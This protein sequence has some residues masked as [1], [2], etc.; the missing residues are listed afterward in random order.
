[1]SNGADGVGESDTQGGGETKVLH[2]GPAADMGAGPSKDDSTTTG[3]SISSSLG[4][5]RPAVLEEVLDDEI[6][7]D[8]NCLGTS[9][10][11]GLVGCVVASVS[12]EPFCT[13]EVP[14]KVRRYRPSF[15]IIECVLEFNP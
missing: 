1:M 2:E 12:R 8:F 9:D 4:S 11:F 15:G 13:T 6:I 7:A 10:D 5:E 14:F 3:R